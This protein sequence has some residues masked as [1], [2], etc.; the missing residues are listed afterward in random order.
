MMKQEIYKKLNDYSKYEFSNLGNIKNIITN[1]IIKQSKTT[2]GYL[3]VYIYKDSLKRFISVK[4]HRLIA[5]TFLIKEPNMVIDHIDNNKINNNI[6]NLEYVSNRYNILKM[7]LLKNN[8]FFRKQINKNSITFITEFWIEKERY[9]FYS[10]D[11]NKCIDF[12]CLH[13]EPI[14]PKSCKLIKDFYNKE[15]IERV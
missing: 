4:V 6:E 10:K 11:I 15:N 5:E 12:Y 9:S 1:K 2:K 13:I 7:Y 3:G 14:C 8:Q